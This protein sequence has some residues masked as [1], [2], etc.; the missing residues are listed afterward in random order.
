M[1]EDFNK[2]LAAALEALQ[3][4]LDKGGNAPVPAA[5]EEPKRYLSYG[6]QL[7]LRGKLKGLSRAELGGVLG[8]QMAKEG[9]GIPVDVWM[10]SGGGYAIEQLMQQ[11]PTV[12]KALD[13][14]AGTAL[15]RQ[16]LE[17][18]LY[19]LFIRDFPAWDRFP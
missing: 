5:G 19:E 8:S 15:I 7:E 2:R 13:T 17:P 9:Q 4:D 16:D 10:R 18:L 6:D 3:P 12:R 14:T 11:N 1:N